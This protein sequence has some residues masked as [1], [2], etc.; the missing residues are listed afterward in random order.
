MPGGSNEGVISD[1]LHRGAFRLGLVSS[2]ITDLVTTSKKSGSVAFGT[3]I[4]IEENVFNSFKRLFDNS[5]N[6][7]YVIYNTEIEMF[8][9]LASGEIDATSLATPYGYFKNDLSTFFQ[10]SCAS[11]SKEVFI[12][13]STIYLSYE[14][15]VQTINANPNKFKVF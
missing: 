6:L 5:L 9:G 14:E 4:D 1:I 11:F 15:V 2:K 3:A 7:E 12:Y 10:S 8:K 13:T